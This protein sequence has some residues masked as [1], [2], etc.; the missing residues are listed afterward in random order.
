MPFPYDYDDTVNTITE[1]VVDDFT[2]ELRKITNLGLGKEELAKAKTYQPNYTHAA[3]DDKADEGYEKDGYFRS[4]N[5]YSPQIFGAP[6]PRF[7]VPTGGV[8]FHQQPYGWS[9]AACFQGDL[10]GSGDYQGVSHSCTRVKLRHKA[11][12]NIMTSFY[13]FEFGGM[14]FASGGSEDNNH[15]LE[16]KPAGKVALKVDDTVYSGSAWRYIHVANVDTDATISGLSGSVKGDLNHCRIFFNMIGRHQHS[17]SMQVNLEPGIHDIGL[18]V[19][20]LPQDPKNEMATM[21]T[22]TDSVYG[23]KQEETPCFN[24]RKQIFFM[25]RNFVVDIN[26][27]GNSD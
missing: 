18:A 4:E 26:Y 9:N 20:S 2:G 15:G 14:N 13:C 6:Q 25:N 3:D 8:H 19:R 1:Q 27:T 17:I 5:F 22:P 12:V 11:I 7:L 24:V 16:S 21:F 10:T 23:H